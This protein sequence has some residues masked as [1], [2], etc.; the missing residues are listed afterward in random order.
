MMN[1][2]KGRDLVPGGGVGWGWGALVSQIFKAVLTLLRT[3][4]KSGA[5]ALL[6]EG[7]HLDQDCLVAHPLAFYLTLT[8]ES[9]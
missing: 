7:A 8:S 1:Q 3:P 9:P 4:C 2:G 6:V 5:E